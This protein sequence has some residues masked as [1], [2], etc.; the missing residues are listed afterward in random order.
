[1]TKSNEPKHNAAS[2]FVMSAFFLVASVTVSVMF[3]LRLRPA[4]ALSQSEVAAVRAASVVANRP[5]EGRTHRMST[6]VDE[7]AAPT[8]SSPKEAVAK[9]VSS[10]SSAENE[11]LL[12]EAIKL[13]DGES[14]DRAK[15]LLEQILA[16]EPTNERVLIELGMIYLIDERSP[17]GA[18]P[19]LE[20][21]LSSN[22]NNRI[23]AAELLGVYDEMG[24]SAGGEQYLRGLLAK[25][26][27]NGTIALSLGQ[28]YQSR[29]V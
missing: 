4:P 3:L 7:Q 14:P 24:D 26:P 18:R 19:Y 21:A 23:V 25:N 1:M 20:R 29:T 8:A 9:S 10:G 5:K 15:A 13:V 17:A 6:A 22:P 11:S 12:A 16:Q 2:H 28:C 27:D